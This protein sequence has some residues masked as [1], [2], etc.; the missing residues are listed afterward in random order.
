MDLEEGADQRTA[1]WMG[2][3]E[4]GQR[5]APA[6]SDPDAAQW[7]GQI[8]QQPTTPPESSFLEMSESDPEWDPAYDFRRIPLTDDEADE[9][10][11]IST[12]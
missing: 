10:A 4:Q 1:E 5:T 11:Q 6:A 7:I 2:Q 3:I 12:L 8:D 9:P